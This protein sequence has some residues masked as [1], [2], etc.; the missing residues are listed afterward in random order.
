MK[1]TFW[2]QDG[3]IELSKCFVFFIM[4]HVRFVIGFYSFSVR[5][6]T[7]GDVMV[8]SLH[9][10]GGVGDGA[11][12]QVPDEALHTA[13]SLSPTHKEDS[14]TQQRS[15]LVANLTTLLKKRKCKIFSLMLLNKSSFKDVILCNKCTS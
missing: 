6:I 2:P 8:D 1:Y 13:M 7:C 10:D 4:L 3:V 14:K 5:V 9:R 11:S 12:L 15:F